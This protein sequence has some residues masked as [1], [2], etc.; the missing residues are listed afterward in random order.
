MCI[1]PNTAAFSAAPVACGKG[2]REVRLPLPQDAGDALL[3]YLERARPR[4]D[5]DRMFLR[6][7]APYRPF[8]GP[9]ALSDVVRLI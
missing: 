1:S 5:D 7:S 4:V 8:A 2:R 9:C 3:G 6:S